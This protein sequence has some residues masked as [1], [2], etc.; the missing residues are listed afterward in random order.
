M[1]GVVDVGVSHHA[2]ARLVVVVAEV[3]ERALSRPHACEV[4]VRRVAI[5][6][7]VER[8]AMRRGGKGGTYGTLRSPVRVG[9]VRGFN[10]AS[11]KANAP[12]GPS[13]RDHHAVAFCVSEQ[14]K[15]EPLLRS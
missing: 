14:R 7:P 13:R 10:S 15:P 11:S 4:D 9:V 8:P 6:V 12:G 1:R 5:R 2:D 3:V